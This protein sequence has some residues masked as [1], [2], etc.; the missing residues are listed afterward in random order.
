MSATF[1]KKKRQV[2]NEWRYN[3]SYRPN[4]VVSCESLAFG[5]HMA[6][7]VVSVFDMLVKLSLY[8]VSYIII[9]ILR[10]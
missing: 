9:D 4:E 6:M 10:L 3:V 8:I 7:I 5:R 1:S 2:K